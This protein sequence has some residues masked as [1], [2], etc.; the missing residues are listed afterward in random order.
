MKLEIIDV[1]HGACAFIRTSNGKAVMIDCG[2]NASTGW[3]PGDA[4]VN[5]GWSALDRLFITNYD[6]D[7]V[8]GYPN[9]VENVVVK[10]LT[11]NW[12]VSVDNIR[13]LKTRDGMGP[14]IDCLVRTIDGFFLGGAPTADDLNFGDT[15]FD[16]FANPYGSPPFGF[17]DENNLSLVVFVTCGVHRI[18][19]PGDL[20]KAGWKSLLRNQEFCR[21]LRGV[22]IFVASHHGRENG[23]CKEVFDVCGNVQTVIISDK[24]KHHQTQETV[25]AYRNHATG[26]MY[27]GTLRRVLTTRQDGSMSFDLSEQ[28]AI[29][30]LGT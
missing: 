9:L 5:A 30:R 24:A 15:T 11:R 7:H 21:M 6:E 1:E 4:L 16:I 2:H 29:V 12:H 3:Y 19:F 14:G 20:E 13:S 23:Y 26:F 18:I 27:D 22:T 28:G 25:P 8:S 17:D 10:L